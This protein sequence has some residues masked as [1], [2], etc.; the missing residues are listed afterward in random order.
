[1]RIKKA[2]V[3]PES[4]SESKFDSRASEDT[5]LH[6]QAELLRH[7]K[8][9]RATR[10]EE[11]RVRRREAQLITKKRMVKL[12][13]KLRKADAHIDFTM[14]GLEATMTGLVEHIE[15]QRARKVDKAAKTSSLK[16]K[17]EEAKKHIPLSLD[18]VVMKPH[19]ENLSEVMQME[20][21][22]MAAHLDAESLTTAYLQMREAEKTKSADKTSKMHKRKLEPI[23]DPFDHPREIVC[24]VAKHLEGHKMSSELEPGSFL[25]FD[26]YGR[27]LG[28]ISAPI[29]LKHQA[30]KVLDDTSQLDTGQRHRGNADSNKMSRISDGDT[31]S[32]ISRNKSEIKSSPGVLRKSDHSVRQEYRDPKL[33]CLELM[34]EI[35]NVSEDED[36]SLEKLKSLT[37]LQKPAFEQQSFSDASVSSILSSTSE[38]SMSSYRPEAR[39][40]RKKPSS[41]AIIAR[42]LGKELEFSEQFGLPEW[43]NDEEFDEYP[44]TAFLRVATP[45]S[46]RK[47]HGDSLWNEVERNVKLLQRQAALFGQDKIFPIYVDDFEKEK[48]KQPTS[49]SAGFV[50]VKKSSVKGRTGKSALGVEPMENLVDV[51]DMKNRRMYGSGGLRIPRR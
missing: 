3:Y 50:D 36:V 35:I 32:L 13:T 19:A 11:K 25:A 8:A 20:R 45:G 44:S 28:E 9:E 31:Q 22:R 2:E 16:E 47:T 48:P 14:K 4:I 51:V 37:R 27:C 26:D 30:G 15:K 40:V 10:K 42:G 43:N 38:S 24:P 21:Q 41:R 1:M 39:V 12:E 7:E 33:E 17:I 29:V 46:G 6:E 18:P 49:I 5:D 34:E 23:R